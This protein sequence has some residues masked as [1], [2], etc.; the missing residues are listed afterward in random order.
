MT[1]PAPE[2]ATGIEWLQTGGIA[3]TGFLQE[4]G[5]SFAQ[6]NARPFDNMAVSDYYREHARCGRY[7]PEFR[8]A[9]AEPRQM[10]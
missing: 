9:E 1:I 3:V 10:E 5:M 7:Y 2:V 4:E 8:Q 6:K